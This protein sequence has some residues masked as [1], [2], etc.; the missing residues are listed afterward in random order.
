MLW[1]GSRVFVIVVLGAED[2]NVSAI[3]VLLSVAIDEACPCSHVNPYS[4]SLPRS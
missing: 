4:M 2:F 1:L 3:F